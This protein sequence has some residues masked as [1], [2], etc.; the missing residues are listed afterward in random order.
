MNVDLP[1]G[2]RP[3]LPRA[4]VLEF[5]RTCPED[6]FSAEQVYKLLNGDTRNVSLATVYRVLAQLVDV[7]LVSGAAFGDGRMGYELNNG[8][9]HDH[10]VCTACVEI[11]EFFDAEIEAR[12]KVIADLHDF[13]MTSRQMVLYGVCAGCRATGARLKAVA[14]K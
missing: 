8:D 11:A 10:I 5:F 7:N 13:A 12:Q 14:G 9:P 3:T 4:M 6:H 2:L 1:A